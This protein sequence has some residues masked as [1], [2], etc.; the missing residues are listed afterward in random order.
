MEAKK[1]WKEI[2][3]I[4]KTNKYCVYTDIA[5]ISM[6][7]GITKKQYEEI[8]DKVY[9]GTITEKQILRRIKKILGDDD[10]GD[11]DEYEIN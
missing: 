10:D 3:K 8:I 5:I 1:L 6:K 9:F 4:K 11:G 2:Q 7:L